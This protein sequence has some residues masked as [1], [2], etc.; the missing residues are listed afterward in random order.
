VIYLGGMDADVLIFDYVPY[1][2]LD[3]YIEGERTLFI[4]LTDIVGIDTTSSGGPTLHYTTDGGTTWSS[5]TYGLGSNN[6]FDSGEL[7]SIGTCG[8][9]SST[10]IF[11]V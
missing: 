4:K 10:C 7:V 2:G 3:S 11:K 1:T 8:S 9:S 5:T 6:E